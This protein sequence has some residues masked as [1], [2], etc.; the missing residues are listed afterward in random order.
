[1]GEMPLT[2]HHEPLATGFSSQDSRRKLARGFAR[3]QDAGSGSWRAPVNLDEL[4]AGKVRLTEF[5]PPGKYILGGYQEFDLTFLKSAKSVQVNLVKPKTCYDM[6]HP[7]AQVKPA[8]DYL[9]LVLFLDGYRVI[10]GNLPLQLLSPREDFTLNGYGVGI[11]HSS[12]FA[13]RR[14]FLIAEGPAPSFAY[15]VRE[16]DGELLALNSHTFGLEQIF[17]RTHLEA[18]G[19]WWECTLTSYERIVDIIK[20][21]VPVPDEMVALIRQQALEYISPIYLTYRDDNLR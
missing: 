15:L 20:Y 13:E 16:S 17:L 6:S 1:V 21:R 19:A 9:E 2:I 12:D 4:T 8:F 10:I 7:G 14:E 11:L 18:E 3:V 5:A